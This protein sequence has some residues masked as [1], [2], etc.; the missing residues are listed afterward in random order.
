MKTASWRWVLVMG[1]LSVAAQIV[2]FQARFGH[3]NTDSTI[4]DYLLFFLAGALGGWILAFFLNRQASRTARRTVWIAFLLAS[5]FALLMMIAGGLL[6]P[7]G[8]LIF[9]QIPWTIFPWVGSWLGRFLPD[10]G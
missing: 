7:F 5:P 8:V 10:A 6:G 2:I 1:L 4:T 3:W 9:P